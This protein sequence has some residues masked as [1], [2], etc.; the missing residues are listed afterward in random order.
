M[1][2]SGA[3]RLRQRARQIK[4]IGDREVE[5]LGASRRDDVGRVAGQEQRAVLHRLGDEA[6]QRRNGFFD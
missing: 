3:A 6:A 2:F 4:D 1:S 5:A